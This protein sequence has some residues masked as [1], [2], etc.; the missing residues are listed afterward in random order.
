[1]IMYL[2]IDKAGKT[3]LLWCGSMRDEL[4]MQAQTGI[5]SKVSSRTLDFNTMASNVILNKI[6][7]S[8]NRTKPFK[9]SKDIKCGYCDA[10]WAA[11]DLVYLNYG[12]IITK[13]GLENDV[14][15][16]YQ[17]IQVN[18]QNLQ[19]DSITMQIGLVNCQK[20]NIP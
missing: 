18:K 10:S 3:N 13:F 11:K 16:Q 15:K 14:K 2:K 20:A 8:T 1:M 17:Q 6:T 9:I 7:Y 4:F 12:T 5:D 19:K